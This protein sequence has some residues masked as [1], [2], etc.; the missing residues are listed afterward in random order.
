MSVLASKLK[1][2]SPPGNIDDLSD[3][4]RAGWSEAVSSWMSNEI[5][6]RTAGRTPLK[7]FFD[8][9]VTAYRQAQQGVKITWT[10]F[11]K[12]ACVSDVPSI[13]TG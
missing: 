2:F 7:Q 11:P 9:T 12:R 6:G 8:G 10:G 13:R 3:A 5:T 1:V 4:N